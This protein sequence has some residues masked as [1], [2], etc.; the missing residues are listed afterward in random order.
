[1]I[2]NTVSTVTA[3]VDTA[4]VSF[5]DFFLNDVFSA[6]APAPFVFSFQAV[7]TLGVPEDLIKISADCDRHLRRRGPPPMAFVTI[8]TTCRRP[9]L[10]R[11]RRRD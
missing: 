6:T 11:C 1:M 5:V 4:D 3:T 7:P 10:S 2:E 8:L 9:S